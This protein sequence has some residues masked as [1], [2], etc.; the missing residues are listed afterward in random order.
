MGDPGEGKKQ[1]EVAT[2]RVAQPPRAP[3]VIGDVL[4]RIERAA[5][6]ATGGLS[7][8]ELLACAAEGAAQGLDAYGLSLGQVREGPLADGGAVTH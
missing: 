2:P 8:G 5:D 3:S 1:R 4:E 7:Q 6:W